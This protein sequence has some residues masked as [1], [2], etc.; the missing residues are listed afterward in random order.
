MTIVAV[1]QIDVSGRS[2]QNMGDIGALAASIERLGLLHPV[3]VTPD[4]KL[5]V[6][7]RRIEALKLLGRDRIPANVVRNLSELQPL[8]EAE[9]DE[10]LCREPYT[11]EEAVHLARRFEPVA[12]ELARKAQADGRQ[13]GGKNRHNGSSRETFPEAKGDDSRRARAQTAAVVGMSDRTLERAAAVV[14]SGDCGLVAEMNRTGKVNGVYRRL[15]VQQKAA[16]IAS[17]PP[18]LPAGPYRVIVCDPPWT[19]DKRPDDPTHRAAPPYPSMSLA[20]IEALDVRSMACDDSVL[21]LWTTNAHLPHAFAVAAAWGFEYKTTLTW[22][23]NRMGCG[24]WLRGRT[25]HCLMCVRG[26]PTVV[27]SNQTTALLADAG[28]HSAKPPEFYT[29]VEALCPGSRLE[30]F[31]RTPRDGWIGH[32]DECLEG[33]GA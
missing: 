4:N 1:S 19:Y 2:R 16:A 6:G 31:Q 15:V 8:L 23:K 26:R 33:G 17:E 12:R 7:Q 3:V 10:N 32:G 30:M 22:M 29:L 28:P 18:P 11:P 25:E 14:D 5:V 21:W 24:D 27:L 9:R 20:E 13:K